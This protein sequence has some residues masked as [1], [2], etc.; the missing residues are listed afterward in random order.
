MT[1]IGGWTATRPPSTTAADY[2]GELLLL[3]LLL[4]LLHCFNLFFLVLLSFFLM[5]LLR[6]LV[7][8]IQ[9]SES[10]CFG[11]KLE[12]PRK[13]LMTLSSGSNLGASEDT[14]DTWE[15]RPKAPI[16]RALSPHNYP[17]LCSL[18]MSTPQDPTDSTGGF[19]KRKDT[20][21]RPRKVPLAEFLRYFQG[22]VH[23]R[24]GPGKAWASSLKLECKV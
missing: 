15:P 5:V 19:L 2:V 20:N 6:L 1:D 11:S 22:V 13:P 8:E 10:P 16:P 23:G 9:T 7:H 21:P 12:L 3:E 4:L 18:C 17:L 24:K 14:A